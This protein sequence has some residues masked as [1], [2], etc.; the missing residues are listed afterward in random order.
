MTGLVF[1]HPTI[2][3]PRLVLSDLLS[4]Y[5]IILLCDLNYNLLTPSRLIFSD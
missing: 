4:Y 1:S 5:L 3:S 2:T